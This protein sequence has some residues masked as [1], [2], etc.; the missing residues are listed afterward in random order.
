MKKIIPIC[1]VSA[2]FLVGCGKDE[3]QKKYN[4]RPEQHAAW[5]IDGVSR[6]N[7]A[8]I[9]KN[10]Y[11]PKDVSDRATFSNAVKEA[12]VAQKAKIDA[13]GGIEKV[14]VQ[15]ITVK[16]AVKLKKSE[17]PVET[18]VSMMKTGPESYSTIISP[19]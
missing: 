6:G 13:G 17:S 12:L 15:S 19:K 8:P 2:M 3:P 5:F 9:L 18:S 10:I 7:F 4:N 14:N 1:F 11:V 16:L